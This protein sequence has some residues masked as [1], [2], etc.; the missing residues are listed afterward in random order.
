MHEAFRYGNQ[1]DDNRNDSYVPDQANYP[2]ATLCV[3]VG[4]FT[5]CERRSLGITLRETVRASSKRWRRARSAI[6][7]HDHVCNAHHEH[8]HSQNNQDS[9]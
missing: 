9:S 8:E 2:T 6:R 3:N 7:I 1:C 5:I 4:P